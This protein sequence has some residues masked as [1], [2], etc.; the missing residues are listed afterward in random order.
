MTELMVRLRAQRATATPSWI[1]VAGVLLAAGWGSNQFTPMLLI[2]HARLGLSTSTLEALFGAYAAGLIPGLLVAGWW[3]D[4]H[5]R[6]PVAL[7]AAA[8]S[9]LATVTLAAGAHSDVPLFVG[10]LL[11]GLASGAAFGAGTAWLRETSLP[12][13]G[14]ATLAGAGRRAAV[15]MTLGFALGPLITGVLAQWGPDPLVVPYLPHI[16]FTAVVL[17]ALLPVPETLDRAE[18]GSDGRSRSRLS[19]PGAGTPR[20]RRVVAPMAPW[21]FAAPA[22]AFALLPSIVGAGHAADGIAVTAAIT[23]LTAIAGVAIQPFA[24]R[25]HTRAQ[26]PSAG[27]AGL[28]AVTAGLA[29]GALT[30]DVKHTWLLVPSAIVLGAGYGLCLIAGLT[31]VQRLAPP[32]ASAGLTAIFY[33]LTYVGFAAPYL[34]ALGSGIA[35]YPTLLLIVGGLAL[36]TAARV[37]RASAD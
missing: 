5:G 19:F 15:A 24:Q 25:L 31:E 9:L 6:R 12:P 29:L 17:L 27:V 26:P 22:I 16:L 14:S 35:G 2:Y 28:L 7:A 10:R 4:R 36:L 30:A 32:G 34:L 21:V 23:A 13:V 18:P 20:F 37:H 3:S 33:A 1:P 8:L 11:A